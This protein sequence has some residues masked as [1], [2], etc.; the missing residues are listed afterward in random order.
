M[1]HLF[2]TNGDRSSLVLAIHLA[3]LG[4]AVGQPHARR[5]VDGVAVDPLALDDDVADV[6]PDAEL[7]APL[8]GEPR[9]A[10]AEGVLDRRGTFHRAGD[11][12]ELRQQ[13]GA[14]SVDDAAA[15]VRDRLA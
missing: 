13:I 8:F 5:N 12:A 9:V 10:L 3:G 15:K 6:Q 7:E 11:V 4:A 2:G 1:V 14:G